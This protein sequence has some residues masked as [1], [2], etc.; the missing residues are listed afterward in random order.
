V[1]LDKLNKAGYTNDQM[2]LNLAVEY[3]KMADPRLPA[4][5]RKA[6][7]FLETSC[8]VID[9]ANVKLS[10]TEILPYFTQSSEMSSDNYP[11]RL[12]KLF[13]INSTMFQ[14]GVWWVLSNLLDPVTVSKIQVL[15]SDYKDTLLKHIPAE[16]LPAMF[17]GSCQCEG[18]CELSDA[19][20]WQEDE[21]RRP[22]WWEKDEEK[23]EEKKEEAAEGAAAEGE[24]VKAT[25]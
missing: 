13:V 10:K 2:L 8:T 3:E 1:N 12:G 21:W 6:G 23:E 15:G 18:G 4:C 25:A 5:S 14:R 17:G 20:P 7:H 9:V 11:E 16:N 22:A 19:G 24:E